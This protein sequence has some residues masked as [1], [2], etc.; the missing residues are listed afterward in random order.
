MSDYQIWIAQDDGSRLANVAAVS[1]F[2]Y[3]LAYH[4]IGALTLALPGDLDPWLLDEDRIIE[5]WRGPAGYPLRLERN[6]FLRGLVDETDENGVSS[7]LVTGLDGNFLLEGEP[8]AYYAGSSYAEKTGPADDL[9]KAVVRENL[10]ALA[11]DTARRRPSAQFSVAPDLSQGPTITKAFAYKSV[12]EA[13]WG[14]SQAAREAGTAVYFD[15]V[16]LAGGRFEFRT[17]VD[18][19]GADRSRAGGNPLVFGLER[20]NLQKPRLEKDW[21]QEVNYVYAGGKGEGSARNIETAE[22][23][24]RSGR[25][26][27]A[28]RAAFVNASNQ[29]GDGLTAAAQRRLGEGRPK[30]SFGANILSVPGALYGVDWFW[31]DRVVAAHRGLDYNAVIDLV[32]VAVSEGGEETVDARLEVEA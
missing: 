1:A 5:V 7:F 19:P 16:S 3:V 14:L 20:R 11:T 13:L 21:T 24:S 29:T 10:G 26:L 25:S 2:R 9:M 18:Q 22:D 15:V 31:G 27:W 32:D 28:R 4:E 6:F 8:V 17:L 23:L 30:I 12:L